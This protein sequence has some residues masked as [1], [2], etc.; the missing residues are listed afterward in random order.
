MEIESGNRKCKHKVE[1]N[2]KQKVEVE[3][4][5]IKWT[6]RGRIATWNVTSLGDQFKYAIVLLTF[7]EPTAGCTMDCPKRQHQRTVNKSI[8]TSLICC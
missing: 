8:S 1:K 2:G 6:N 7:S 3:S 4:G 5:N